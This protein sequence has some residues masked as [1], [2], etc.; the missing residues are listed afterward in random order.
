LAELFDTRGVGV[1]LSLSFADEG[2]A[3]VDF[4]DDAVSHPMFTG[5]RIMVSLPKMS[6][7]FTAKV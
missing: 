7:T 5:T 4:D 3:V 1:D 2:E 6:I